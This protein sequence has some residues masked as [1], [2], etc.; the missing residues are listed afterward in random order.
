MHHLISVTPKIADY[1]SFRIGGTYEYFKHPVILYGLNVVEDRAVIFD[2]EEEQLVHGIRPH[3]LKRIE[4]P[5]DEAMLEGLGFERNNLENEKTEENQ[6]YEYVCYA[7]KAGYDKVR[8]FLGFS[9]MCN[10]LITA[11]TAKET[12]ND[13]NAHFEITY[14]DELETIL[15]TLGINWK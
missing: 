13:I 15:H 11:H 14:L 5:D 1:T 9:Y 7:G 12:R 2:Y 3:D 4:L 10:V 6:C 8:I